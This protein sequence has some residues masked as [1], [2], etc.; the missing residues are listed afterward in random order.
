MEGRQESPAGWR[1]STFMVP[2]MDCPSEERMVRLALAPLAGVGEL[3]VDLPGRLLRVRHE[4]PVE[5]V[6][7]RLEPLRYGAVLCESVRAPAAPAAVPAPA[8]E[9]GT[10]YLLL[11]INA[12]MFVVELLAG[13]WAESTGLLT[14]ALDMLADAGVY[15]IALYAATRGAAQQ[16]RAAHLSGWLQLGLAMG[17]LAEVLRRLVFGS[18]PE[19]APMMA[20]ALLALA[21]NTVCLWLVSRQR[22]RGAHMQASFIFSSNDVLANLG[23]ILA[24]ALVAWTGAAWPDLLIGTLIGLL[25]LDGAR[26]ILALGK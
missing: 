2:G 5:E 17:A 20:I 14:D 19:A 12:L 4:A 13:W 21:A 24:G 7:A 22:D 6:L 23:V 11:G 1:L 18:A 16:L 3:E 8:S 10:L 9:A 15:G 26:R 25:V